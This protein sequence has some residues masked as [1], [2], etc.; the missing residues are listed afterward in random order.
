MLLVEPPLETALEV[1][2][3]AYCELLSEES[4]KAVIGDARPQ[5]RVSLLQAPRT[6]RKTGGATVP[7]SWIENMIEAAT[8]LALYS[9]VINNEGLWPLGSW[10]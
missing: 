9:V 1:G 7:V 6:R 3:R 8:D 2:E 4:I 10:R 5:D